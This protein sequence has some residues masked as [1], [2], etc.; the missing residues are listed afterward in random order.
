MDN[1]HNFT[2]RTM[3]EY[4]SIFPTVASVLDHQLFT[5]GNG[6]EMHAGMPKESDAIHTIDRNAVMDDK[7]WGELLNHC[8]E[9]ERKWQQQSGIENNAALQEKCKKYRRIDVAD[10][11]FSE[12]SLYN[13]LLNMKAT[14]NETFGED[15]FF[16]RPYPLS[17]QYSKIYKLDKVTPQ[18]FIQIAIN[19]CNAWIRFLSES[20]DIGYVS[21][22][23]GWEDKEHT[24]KHRDMLIEQVKHLRGIHAT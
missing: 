19:V 6:F 2:N 21:S 10:A 24:A 12:A 1:I 3:C 16:V 8:K 14:S 22:E 9:K 23:P 18:W 7:A 20:I 15:C 13:D 4:A 17:I 5:I 11:D